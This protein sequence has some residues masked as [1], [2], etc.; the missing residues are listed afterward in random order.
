MKNIFV[1][2]TALLLEVKSCLFSSEELNCSKTGHREGVWLCFVLCFC[3]NL[4]MKQDI[5]KSNSLWVWDKPVGCEGLKNDW[6]RNAL[7]V[8][9][10]CMLCIINMSVLVCL[11]NQSER[12][13]L[14]ENCSGSLQ[15]TSFVCLEQCLSFLLGAPCHRKRWSLCWCC[16]F[17]L[18]PSRCTSPRTE[19]LGCT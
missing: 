1:I 14:I 9:S 12:G 18:T 19:L 6:K 8:F 16:T 10:L 17:G 5:H 11:K 7:I 4:S 15:I 2:R 13:M 3:I